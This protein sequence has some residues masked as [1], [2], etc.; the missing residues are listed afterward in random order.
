MFIILRKYIMI[1]DIVVKIVELAKELSKEGIETS[2]DEIVDAL[3]G[4]LISEED[5]CDI[6]KF[7]VT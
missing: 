6:R 2:P 4:D 7:I 5:A 3:S 1:E